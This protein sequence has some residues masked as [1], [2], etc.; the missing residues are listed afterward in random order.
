M[1]TRTFFIGGAVAPFFDGTGPDF[2]PY[3][4]Y[5]LDDEQVKGIMHRYGCTDLF[6]DIPPPATPED[7]AAQ[8]K[9]LT[10]RRGY[11]YKH[12]D[13]HW[14]MFIR[15]EQSLKPSDNGFGLQ[16]WPKATTTHE[17]FCAHVNEFFT[18]TSRGGAG[19]TKVYEPADPTKPGAN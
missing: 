5:S 6:I 15:W 11:V 8:A 1:S 13:T 12:H 19:I 14:F 3:E 17:Q 7:F 18:N 10:Q 4:L 2:P 16:A 9:G